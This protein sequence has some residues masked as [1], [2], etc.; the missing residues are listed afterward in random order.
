MGKNE[1]NF[2]SMNQSFK[3]IGLSSSIP[4]SI[5]LFFITSHTDETPADALHI[6]FDYRAF[7]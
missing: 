6:F 2:F 7:F 3:N 5:A 1:T 4:F